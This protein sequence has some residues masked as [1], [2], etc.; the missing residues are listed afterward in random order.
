M[1]DAT[2]GDTHTEGH[3]AVVSESATNSNVVD[4]G[5]G[6]PRPQLKGALMIHE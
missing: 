6:V 2:R 1:T 3:Q 4:V 5:D